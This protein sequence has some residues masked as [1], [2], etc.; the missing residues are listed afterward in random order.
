MKII[1]QQLLQSQEMSSQLGRMILNY[2][3]TD[4]AILISLTHLN[5]PLVM[6]RMGHSWL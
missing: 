5:T 4:T 6:I 2:T 1:V 3:V